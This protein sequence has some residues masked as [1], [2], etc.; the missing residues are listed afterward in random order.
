[1]PVGLLCYTHQRF[2]TRASLQDW[3]EL[4]W[5]GSIRIVPQTTE[6][7]E[8]F[9]ALSAILP[10]DPESLRTKGFWVILEDKAAE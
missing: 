10:S 6:L 8:A 7:P 3:I 4:A 2:F 5:Q 1:V 9:T